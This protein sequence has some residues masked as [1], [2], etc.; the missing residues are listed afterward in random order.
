[1]SDQQR[2][3]FDL[4]YG[5][6]TD[7]Y[8]FHDWYRGAIET[9]NSNL[10]DKISQAGNSIRELCDKLPDRL[11]D[12][13]KFNSPLNAV[14][15]LEHPFLRVKSKEYPDGWGSKT[16]SK[17]LEKILNRLEHAFKVF[18]E[19]VRTA[20]LRLALTASDINADFMS[21]QQRAVRDEIFRDIGIFF[22]DAAHHKRSITEEE[23][24]RELENF[25]SVLLNYLTPCTADQQNELLELIKNP[26]VP[27]SVARVNKLI[28]YKGANFIF[29]FEKLDNPL[30]LKPLDEHGFF[31]DL[32]EPE[33]TEDGKV[34]YPVHIPLIGLAKLAGTD[35]K[36][37]SSILAKLRIPDN[38]RVGDQ[39]IQCMAK[40]RDR[41]SAT[42][43]RPLLAQLSK[44]PSRVSWHR[45]EELL[46]NWI[47]LELYKEVLWIVQSFLFAT[48]DSASGEMYE[49]DTWLLK[50]IDGKFL[51]PLGVKFPFESVE[52]YFEALCRKAALER[53]RYSPGEIDEDGPTSYWIEDFT[54]VHPH[55]RELEGVLARCLFAAAKLVYQKGDVPEINRLDELLRS[56]P[57]QLFRRL[58]CQL[59]ADFPDLSLE[60]AKSE[61]L[62]RLPTVNQIDYE[63]GSVD[64]EFAQLLYAFSNKYRDAF[65]SP[66]E[67]KLYAETVMTGPL[68]YDGNVIDGLEKQSFQRKQLWPISSLLT[69]EHLAF[70]N[71]LVP[72]AKATEFDSYKPFRSGA[73]SYERIQVAP[74]E[75]DKLDSMTDGE[76]WSFLNTW[77]PK[78]EINPDGRWLKEDPLALA[79]KLAETVARHPDRFNAGKR[80]WENLKRPVMVYK[81]LE[82]AMNYFVGQQNDSKNLAA[83]PAEN[84]WA[85]WFG[86]AKWTIANQRENEKT[87]LFPEEP[88][89]D[90][91]GNAAVRFFRLA[92]KSKYEIPACHISD[93]RDA[94]DSIIKNDD[95]RWD[96]SMS[97]R[98][99]N[100]LTDA[101]NSVRGNAIE[102]M[103][104]LAY[105][106]KQAGS[107]IEE[108]I[109]GLICFCLI[110]EEESPAVFALLGANLRFFIYLFEDSLKQSP[111][112]L[113]PDKR[114]SHRRAAID[115][116]FRYDQAHPAVIRTFPNLIN[117]SLQTLKTFSKD[118][119]ND[120]TKRDWRD[121]GSRL[122]FHIAFYYWNELF[123]KDSDAET[124]LGTYFK[125]ASSKA[126]ARLIQDIGTCFERVTAEKIDPKVAAGVMRIWDRRYSQIEEEAKNSQTDEF[127]GELT[128]FTDWLACECFPF[129]WR[130]SRT[131]QAVQM[132]KKTGHSRQLLQNIG[133]IGLQANRLAAALKLLQAILSKPSNE[134]R[135]S[136]QFNELASLISAGLSDQDSDIQKCANEC[137]N[138]LLTMGCSAFLKLSKH[139]N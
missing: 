96:V 4:L 109:F 118:E 111:N 76:L 54:T 17:S 80:W 59:Y 3:V 98:M 20:R 74:P 46:K 95:S 137:L 18:N 113:F 103:L 122:G 47:E 62:K 28:S 116:H 88:G 136:I 105:R 10:P 112:L 108:W 67:V 16:I 93:L 102:A 37:V 9:I 106:Q 58:R 69:G 90:W 126:R 129:E 57:W 138:S 45:I 36:G 38:P 1:M 5:L 41:E 51:R 25:E 44:R 21:A 75:A 134:L 72:E 86:V 65:L 52:I 139:K 85:N 92:L 104:N 7:L 50:Q 99:E 30:W 53:E 33:P 115:S 94:F 101:I 55:H 68:D 114:P 11:A 32:P 14:K 31:D 127:D 71:A 8:N 84:D 35:P 117:I 64:Y 124:A 12:I 131:I 34:K 29:F 123:L 132:L 70:F 133:V 97:S 77:K 48:I 42:K 61:V 100:W 110:R 119:A 40:I 121:F 130:I 73:T 63:S 128:K 83:A 43:L 19:P 79:T 120:K 89:W 13:P 82:T 2:Q 91:V 15:Q 81:C 60:R 22:Q 107:K 49:P 66:A 26:P 27:D 24:R 56:N 39:I 135:W 23:F 125:L 6:G 78:N 87:R